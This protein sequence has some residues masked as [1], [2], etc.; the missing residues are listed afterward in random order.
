MRDCIQN[1]KAFHRGVT[2]LELLVTIA[3]I[4]ILAAI[5]VPY[6]GDYIERQRLVGASEAI[7]GIALQ[8]KRAAISNNSQ[9]HLVA[10]G[11]DTINWC[12]TFSGVS[13]AVNS[14]DCSGGY[15]TTT[16]NTSVRVSSDNYPGI[17]LL[18]S[19]SGAQA[20]VGFVMPGVSVSNAQ[21]FTLR[22]SRLGDINVEISDEMQ[23]VIC[24][25]DLSQYPDC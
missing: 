2:F 6:Y 4:G 25:D 13:S 9:I 19:A 21:T 12:A 14:S 23:T 18:S 24:S 1:I 17:S 3:I 10:N 8:A 15:V 5:A 16:A 11:L 7:Y 22:S 20:M